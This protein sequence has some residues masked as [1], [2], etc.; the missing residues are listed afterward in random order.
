MWGT[1]GRARD[2]DGKGWTGEGVPN[3]VTSTRDR[4]AI[5]EDRE[6]ERD[7]QAR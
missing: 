6:R 2:G 3:D 1:E 4:W 5:M 7:E